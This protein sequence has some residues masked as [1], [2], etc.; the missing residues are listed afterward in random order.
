MKKSYLILI[1]TVLLLSIGLILANFSPALFISPDISNDVHYEGSVCVYKNG[2]LVECNHNLLYNIGKAGIESCL[3]TAVC[4]APFLNISLCNS[5][6]TSSGCQTPIADASE[7]FTEYTECGLG[8][9]EG[10]YASIADGN[11]TVTNTFTST[12]DAQSMNVTRLQNS[13]GGNLA[14]NTFT[15]VTLQNADTLTINWSIGIV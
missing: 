8:N 15:E 4:P 2:E 7:T 10:A 9:F 13:T 14:G 1:S 6:A 12:C 3:G 11:W 5:T